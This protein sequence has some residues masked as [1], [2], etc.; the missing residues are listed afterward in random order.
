MY[1]KYWGENETFLHI[2]NIKNLKSCEN[3][4]AVE[5]YTKYLPDVK[6]PKTVLF[7]F[8]GNMH[9]LIIF[10]DVFIA[11]VHDDSKFP[12][13]EKLQYHIV[14]NFGKFL[15]CGILLTGW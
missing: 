8:S 15:L 4:T 9:E 6:V 7:M 2:L 12:D 14:W 10:K 11:C 5:N 1:Q 13:V 3:N